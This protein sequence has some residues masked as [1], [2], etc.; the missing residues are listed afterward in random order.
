MSVVFGVT[1]L[2]A[3]GTLTLNGA[4]ARSG[5]WGWGRRFERGRSESGSDVVAVLP[6]TRDQLIVLWR[7]IRSPSRSFDVGL[8]EDE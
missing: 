2:Y 3:T 1:F 5:E 8:E 7:R 4:F 6:E